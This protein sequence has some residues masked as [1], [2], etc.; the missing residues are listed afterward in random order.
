MLPIKNIDKMNN[1]FIGW[2]ITES[3]G[4]Y[5][6]DSLLTSANHWDASSTR[7]SRADTH[8]NAVGHKLI[9]EVLY[10]EYKKIYS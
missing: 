3:I 2:P 1:N 5:C 9:S 6:F 8:P 10:D 4:G 7:I